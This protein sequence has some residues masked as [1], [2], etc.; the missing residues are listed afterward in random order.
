MRNNL[1]KTGH[2]GS[3]KVSAY[4]TV[5][6]SV[7]FPLMIF[8]F[9]IMIYLLVYSYDRSLLSADS[10]M[11]AVYATEGYRNDKETFLAEADKQFSLIKAERPYLS[12]TGLSMNV[13]KNKNRVIINSSIDLNIPVK[14]ALGNMYDIYDLALSDSKEMTILDPASMMLI[15][16][17]LTRND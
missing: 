14:N 10:A 3:G 8:A 7:V 16:G 12:T 15:T 2:T 4:M 13:S 11:M 9:A 1:T 17:D 5:E 6:A